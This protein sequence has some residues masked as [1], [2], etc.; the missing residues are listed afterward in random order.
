MKR[1][2][3]RS[4]LHSL[5]WMKR[6]ACIGEDPELFYPEDRDPQVRHERELKAK[7]IC[8]SCAVQEVCLEYAMSQKLKHGIWGGQTEHERR[9]LPGAAKE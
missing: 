5:E 6:A 3:N 1:S 7:Q 4:R 2:P 8:G 9:I